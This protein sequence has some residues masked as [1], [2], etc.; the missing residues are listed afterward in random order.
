MTKRETTVVPVGSV[1]H[2]TI[3]APV[4]CPLGEG[5][6]VF[7]TVDGPDGHIAYDQSWLRTEVRPGEAYRLA[8]LP[9]GSSYAVRLFGGGLLRPLPDGGSSDQ[10]IGPGRTEVDWI[11]DAEQCAQGQTAQTPGATPV[12]TATDEP[13]TPT[14][15]PSPAPSA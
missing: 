1:L 5:L 9:P 2:G 4:P 11:L 6:A 12:P 3:T 8:G 13:G 7:V 14:P 15:E 10:V